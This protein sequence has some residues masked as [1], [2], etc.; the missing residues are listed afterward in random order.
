[1]GRGHGGDVV[2]PP[3]LGR[4]R[5]RDEWPD[6]RIEVEGSNKG[7]TIFAVLRDVRCCGRRAGGI[8]ASTG[9]LLSSSDTMDTDGA[10]PT[11]RTASDAGLA[12]APA[13]DPA[14]ATELAG[15]CTRISATA[16]GVVPDADGLRD[17]LWLIL[18]LALLRYLRVHGARFSS[19]RAED[20]EDLGAQKS[21]ELVDRIV[22]GALELGGRSGGQIAG[23][24]SVTARNAVLDLARRDGRLVRPED[25]EWERQVN[26]PSE[27]SARPSDS[28]DRIEAVEFSRDLLR[29]LGGL[30]PRS[31][32]IW[33]FRAF[34]ELSSREI[35]SHP[36]VR[37]ESAH[38]DVL[39]QR[40]RE[41]IQ[42]CL[43]R[44][45]HDAGHIPAGTY[46][47]VWE[48]SRS[49]NRERVMPSE[50]LLRADESPEPGDPAH[51]V[52]E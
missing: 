7:E 45:G 3:A 39:M 44:A 15:L 11:T 2:R 28:D 5:L 35:A 26:R 14:W 19:I 1:M 50:Q 47:L 27:Q 38:V 25:H 10:E 52:E 30:Q 20:L 12:E 51:E 8:A 42:T 46:A 24:L 4:R 34:Y 33:F 37:L 13:D 16:S 21:L 43:A 23:F 29:C 41:A 40:S 9:D 48:A 18:R 49:W 22:S 31:R 36:R 17:R 6:G 32:L